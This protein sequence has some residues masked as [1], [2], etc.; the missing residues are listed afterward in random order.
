MSPKKKPVTRGSM[1]VDLRTPFAITV[2]EGLLLLGLGSN[3]IIRN[4]L[5][6]A[7]LRTAS[8]LRSTISYM[9]FGGIV[10]FNTVSFPAGSRQRTV[11]ILV[12][13]NTPL[14]AENPM[15]L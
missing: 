10:L 12:P 1:W 15:M 8:L 7:W 14:H 4:C 6:A 9:R 13:P 5:R 3:D 11:W 2:A